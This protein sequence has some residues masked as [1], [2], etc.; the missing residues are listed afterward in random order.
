MLNLEYLLCFFANPSN[1]TAEKQ[2]LKQEF[3][4]LLFKHALKNIQ[5]RAAI[6]GQEENNSIE[7]PEGAIIN[8]FM[9][10]LHESTIYPEIP[11]HSVGANITVNAFF[12]G[13]NSLHEAAL[14]VGGIVELESQ[15]KLEATAFNGFALV[16]IANCD[17]INL[18]NP[19]SNPFYYGCD[20]LQNLWSVTTTNVPFIYVPV[21]NNKLYIEIIKQY[22]QPELYRYVGS[23][24]RDHLDQFTPQYYR[25]SRN[26]QLLYE[27]IKIYKQL[28]SSVA[29]LFLSEYKELVRVR[30][31]Y[32]TVFRFLPAAITNLYNWMRQVANDVPVHQEMIAQYHRQINIFMGLLN[33]CAD[34]VQNYINELDGYSEWRFEQEHIRNP[35]AF[36]N[37]NLPLRPEHK[38]YVI[39]KALLSL[40]AMY[41]QLQAS[42]ELLGT[43]DNSLSANIIHDKLIF[44]SFAPRGESG[45]KWLVDCRIYYFVDSLVEAVRNTAIRTK[46]LDVLNNCFV[47]QYQCGLNNNILT[48]FQLHNIYTYLLKVLNE[49][50]Y[51]NRLRALALENTSE[52]NKDSMLIFTRST[53]NGRLRDQQLIRTVII[54]R[55]HDNFKLSMIPSRK[56][57]DGT[58]LLPKFKGH[59]TNVT[60]QF[61]ITPAHADKLD[62][63]Q[64]SK[65]IDLCWADYDKNIP[66]QVELFSKTL[67]EE[68]CKVSL[69]VEI[70]RKMGRQV[71]FSGTYIHFKKYN[72]PS[73]GFNRGH[74]CAVRITEDWAIGTLDTLIKEE[75]S[76]SNR[77]LKNDIMYATAIL[78]DNQQE[79]A[80]AKQRIIYRLI[81]DILYDLVKLHNELNVIHNDIKPENILIY[82]NSVGE[83]HA[84][85][86]DFDM[87]IYM[88]DANN[89]QPAATATYASP[90]VAGFTIMSDINSL[91]YDTLLHDFLLKNKFDKFEY[92]SYGRELFYLY[93]ATE[94]RSKYIGLKPDYSDDMF[95]LGVTLFML[96]S[97]GHYPT[98]TESGRAVGGK[99]YMLTREFYD[100]QTEFNDMLQGLLQLERDQR[101]NARDTLSIYLCARQ[102]L[103]NSYGAVQFH[104]KVSPIL[105]V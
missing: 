23:I 81:E 12:T 54:T 30:I 71:I 91:H 11:N 31:Y 42:R 41:R 94:N 18:V 3:S 80:L 76:K 53:E 82:I 51:L 6:H 88:R 90:Q 45:N 61:D 34:T 74:R 64:A 52:M 63:P 89:K 47:S 77:F 16:C 9:Q 100:L 55:S 73:R 37:I 49:P 92:A 27:S 8:G 36:E 10:P 39:E 83:M 13:E 32:C 87:S 78:T 98:E 66:K 86:S 69:A 4:S 38:T 17:A 99:N 22:Y 85:L 2:L 84:W 20:L 56:A 15:N 59:I 44:P 96:L 50:E 48:D 75:I 93:D 43:L 70:A 104:Q 57:C 21:I 25:S 46:I 40:V 60:P 67:R 1:T 19:F 72:D 102:Q 5:D 24:M 7:H 79:I 65:S 35:N 97:G 105:T 14:G 58:H 26:T 103:N 62:P 95:S 101:L 29:D 68:E 28:A 33:E